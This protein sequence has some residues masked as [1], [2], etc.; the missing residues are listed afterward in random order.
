LLAFASLLV[1]DLILAELACTVVESASERAV[2]SPLSVVL[3][4][5]PSAF[6]IV[7]VST[8]LSASG[9]VDAGTS[10][11]GVLLPESFAAVVSD[12]IRMRKLGG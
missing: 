10:T 3:S 12:F 1:A 4:E 11:V 6:S 8:V 2:L 5:G 9:V 7:T